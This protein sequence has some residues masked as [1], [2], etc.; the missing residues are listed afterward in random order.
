M[1]NRSSVSWVIKIGLLLVP[2][3]HLIVTKSL[4]FPFITGRNFIFR[5]II[6]ILFVFWIWLILTDPKYRPK[7]SLIIYAVTAFI[8]I[9]FL[10][11]IFSLS[12]V[13]SFWSNF[14]RMEGFWGHWHYFIYF[15]MLASVFKEKTD[16]S[17]FFGTSLVASVLM[18]FYSLLQLAGRLDVHQGDDRI[19][20]TMGNATYL[21]IYLVFHIF[22][23]LFF[24]FKAKNIWLR[25][26]LALL[27]L[28]ELFIVY[29]TATRGAM[30]GFLAGMMVLGAV[31]S[32][33]S[34]GLV[35]KLSLAVL[36][37]AVVI[38]IL[39][40]FVKD[41]SFV[42][43]SDVLTRFAGISFEETTT[44]SR[45][46]I[47]SIAYQ[48]WQERPVL[49]WGPE[50]FV[51][52]FSKYYDARLWKQ[53]PWF[54]R[55]HNVFFDWLTATGIVGL[56]AYL[57]IFAALFIIL[58]KLLKQKHPPTLIAVFSGL[59][60]A[61]FINNIFVF[62]NFTSY[63]IFFAVAAYL[64][65]YWTSARG[66]VVISNSAPNEIKP[67][68]LVPKS[69][70]TG[71]VFLLVLFSVYSFNVKPILASQSIIEALGLLTY[72]RDGSR[73]RDISLG[74]KALADGVKLNTFGTAEI[75]EQLAQ[76]SERVN[77]DP[78]T[79]D[80]DKEKISKFALEQMKLQEEIFPY[81]VRAKAFLSTLY[82]TA[83]DHANA[84][85]TAQEGLAV[86]S[87][88]QQFYFILA[89]SYFRAGEE[90]LALDTARQ[91]YEL[92]PDYPDAIHNYAMLAIFS[93][94]PELGE[95]LLKKHFGSEIV[96]ELKYVN[97]YAAIGDFKKLIL[98][99]EKI[100]AQNPANLQYRVGLASA[101]ARLGQNQKAIAEL[102]KAIE[103][104]PQFKAQ[105]E[106]FIKQIQEGRFGR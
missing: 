33:R 95:G 74:I 81:D 39:F 76:Y 10:S 8:L 7:A 29:K 53:E 48:A 61:Y 49:G 36:A 63:I 44:Q 67:V 52:L 83:G 22:L 51:Y 26:G 15:L 46:I 88:R 69:I 20:G 70:I 62:D 45:F 19:D 78:A 18:S 97:A 87:Q 24:L 105:G 3:L 5:I 91:A 60:V 50:N 64:H 84:I 16:W 27:I 54:D 40:V 65:W 59:L 11:T 102:E 55:A 32:L 73:V 1:P 99:W 58:F 103:F 94:R 34:S 13:R 79:P 6:E 71:F 82:G 38:P 56:A 4:Y 31:S 80:D 37:V 96:P 2:I 25:A 90:G 75:R 77:Q 72:S 35:R 86:S 42:K 98:V 66:A 17:R 12:P 30:L 85:L 43:N 101:Y 28:F 100:V 47:W 41:S 93:G 92:A 68:P 104:T 14:E 21:A 23:A 9:L 106:A 57:S 89:E